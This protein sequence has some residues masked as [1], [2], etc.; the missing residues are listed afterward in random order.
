MKLVRTEPVLLCVRIEGQ[1]KTFP[2]LP[3]AERYQVTV[4]PC[5]MPVH[6][7]MT[8]ASGSSDRTVVLGTDT[9]VPGE[10]SALPGMK[11]SVYRAEFLAVVRALEGCQP[12]LI[13]N[14]CK[15]VVKAVQTF[16]TGRRHPNGRNK[17]GKKLLALQPGQQI[18]WMKAHQTQA[19]VEHGTVTAADLHGNG[20]ADRLA[21]QGTETH[22]PLGPDATWASWAD[23]ANKVYHFWRFCGSTTLGATRQ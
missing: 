13:V 18:R 6:T 11:Q 22:G 10:S 21:N 12:R 17:P 2:T 23:F 19:A 3:I 1:S 8:D 9:Q 5:V 15:G 7:D 14:D 16:Q 4:P 20:Q